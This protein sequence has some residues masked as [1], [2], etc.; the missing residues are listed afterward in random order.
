RRTLP[1]KSRSGSRTRRWSSFGTSTTRGSPAAEQPAMNNPQ[2]PRNPLYLLLLVAGLVFSVNAVAYAVVPVLE[3]KAAAAGHPAPPSELRAA[4][5]AHGGTWL[6]WELGA[7]V[8]LGFASMAV[9]H[10][11]SLQ[12]QRSA[13]TI[14]PMDPEE[15]A[16]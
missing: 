8:V 7:L 2:E 12:K 3:D 6:L 5:R 1:P 4:L 15:P 14:P 9:D 16:S 13:G 10:L 11:R